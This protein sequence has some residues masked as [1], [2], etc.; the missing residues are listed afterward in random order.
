M[1]RMVLLLSVCFALSVGYTQER[2]WYD[3][4]LDLP[5]VKDI[6]GYFAYQDLRDHTDEQ[7]MR[8][9]RTVQ[10]YLSADFKQIVDSLRVSS[11]VLRGFYDDFSPEK[12]V[13]LVV[14]GSMATAED[15]N[16]FVNHSREVLKNRLENLAFYQK[17]LRVYTPFNAPLGVLARQLQSD[18]PMVAFESFEAI[19]NLFLWRLD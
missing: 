15:D 5:I 7:Y 2:G 10:G 16:L 3:T 4:L 18:L 11:P 12:D 14:V 13:L 1:K 17:F 9:A 6:R 19:N 8:S